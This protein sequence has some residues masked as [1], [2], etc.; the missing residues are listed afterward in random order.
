MTQLLT[1]TLPAIVG[2]GVVLATVTRVFPMKGKGGG[3]GEAHWH[4]KGK[5]TNR[6]VKHIH[7]GGHIS[8]MRKGLPGYGRTKSTLRR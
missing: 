1:T 5:K 8:H 6:A 7:P 4:F 3:K 2:M